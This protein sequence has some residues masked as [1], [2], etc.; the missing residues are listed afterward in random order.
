GPTVLDTL[1]QVRSREPVAP[2]Q[3]QPKVPRDLELICLQCLRKE[4]EKRYPSGA[5][6]ADELRRFVNGEP[7][8]ARPVGR[9]ERLGRWCRRYPGM[10]ALSAAVFALLL[11][12]L[13]VTSLGYWRVSQA[14]QE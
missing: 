9:A 1:E 6:L 5:E 2:R 4:P 14:N 11:A 8:R 10:A 12:T 3:L 13:A 7:V